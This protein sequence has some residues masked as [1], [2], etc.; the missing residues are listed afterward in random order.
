MDDPGRRRVI[1]R[2]AQG[3]K[4]WKGIHV[5][6]AEAQTPVLGGDRK[7]EDHLDKE[8]EKVSSTEGDAEATGNFYPLDRFNAFS[9]AVFAIVITLLVLELPVPPA[10]ARVLPALAES[11]PEFLGYAI[12]FAFVGGIWMSHAGLTK[13]MR[14]GDV[15]SFRLNLV[16]LLFISLLPFST[17]LMVTHVEAA[18]APVAVAVYGANLFM[19]S[20]LITALLYYAVRDRHLVVSDVADDRVRRAYRQRRAY[21]VVTALA[22]IVALVAPVVAVGIYTVVAVGFLIQPLIGMWRKH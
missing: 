17:H 22:I 7:E 15:V 2:L 8:G 6:L 1:R 12:S 9:D 10:S 19:E 13:Y 11:W 4:L 20:A 5:Y 18:D 21:M 3:S 14:R 16:L